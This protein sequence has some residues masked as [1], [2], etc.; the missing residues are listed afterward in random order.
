MSLSN[1]LRL[2]GTIVDQLIFFSIR[3]RHTRLTCDW[4]SD[5][6]SSDLLRAGRPVTLQ[7]IASNTSGGD[8]SART[9]WTS[10]LDGALG[11]G[12]SLVVTT[13]T[14]GV[15]TLTAR[16]T[17]PGN[18]AIGTASG[19]LTIIPAD[20]SLTF[21][22]IADTFATETSPDVAFG[23]STS[24]KINSTPVARAFVRF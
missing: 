24:M 19:R 23:A 22:A 13:L 8:L 20:G 4:S 12:A 3:R 6:C 10:N 1:W 9:V 17:D 18:G 5:V 14:I 7:A 11:T 16:V 15:H 21:V 2:T